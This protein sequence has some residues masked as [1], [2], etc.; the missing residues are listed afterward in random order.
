MVAAAGGGAGGPFMLSITILIALMPFWRGGGGERRPL[1]AEHKDNK[2]RYLIKPD[3][4]FSEGRGRIVK[5][6]DG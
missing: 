1:S 2:Q 5:K 4:F 3:S 6:Q